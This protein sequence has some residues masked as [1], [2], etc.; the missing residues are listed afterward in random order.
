MSRLTKSTLASIVAID[1]SC[2]NAL[3]E[4]HIRKCCYVLLAADWFHRCTSW[5]VISTLCM[6]KPSWDNEESLTQTLG[7]RCGEYEG[8]RF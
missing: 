5:Y 8:A 7:N 6:L 4:R 1:Q 2:R 3:L